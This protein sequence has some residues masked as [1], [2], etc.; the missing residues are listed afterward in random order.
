MKEHCTPLEEAANLASRLCCIAANNQILI[1]SSVEEQIQLEELEALVENSNLK[2][3][4]YRDEQFLIRL[5]DI[6]EVHY[7]EDLKIGD[8][9]KIMGESRSQLY[10]KI[11]EVTNLPPIELINEFRL[12]K[13]IELMN[14]QNGSNI[15]QIAFEAGFNSLSYFSR[16]FKKRYGLLPSAYMHRIS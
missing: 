7:R 10:R 6:I 3:L 15:S 5:M 11:I 1:S 13:A 8:F 4:P 14:T 9:C 12:K 2:S 16:R